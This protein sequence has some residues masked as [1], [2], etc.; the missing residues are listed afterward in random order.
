MKVKQ[1][2]NE[3]ETKQHFLQYKGK[4]GSSKEAYTDGSK[5]TGRKLGYAAVFTDTTRRGALPVEASIHTAEII[6]MKEI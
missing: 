1:T 4:Y 5:S 3:S 6:A 2:G